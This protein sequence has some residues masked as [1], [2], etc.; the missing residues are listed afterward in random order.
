MM[1]VSGAYCPLC[2]SHD[3]AAPIMNLLH[4]TLDFAYKRAM[5]AKKNILNSSNF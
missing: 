4:K 2:Q 3:N 5:Y 1:L